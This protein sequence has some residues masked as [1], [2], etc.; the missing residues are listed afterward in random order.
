LFATALA[1]AFP[2]HAQQT[3][4]ATPV[5]K[6]EVKGT[7]ESYNV[8]RDD[9]ATRIVMNHDEIVKF[10]DT[11][12]LDVLKRLPGVTVSGSGGRGGEVRMRGLGSG[13]TQLLIDGTRAPPGL[14]LDAIAPDTI[15]RIEVIRA[16][17]ADLST[18]AI[19]G[20]IN[21]VLRKAI[22]T[23]QRELSL[24]AGGGEGGGMSPSFNGQLSDRR[25]QLSYSLSVNGSRNNFARPAPIT[26]LAADPDGVPTLLRQHVFQDD[27]HFS[28][29]ALAPRL[30]WTFAS[31][32]TLTWQSRLNLHSFITNSYDTT[33][34]LLGAAPAY[35]FVEEHD[36]IRG[37]SAQTDLNWVTKLASGA[38]LDTR[39]GI[40]GSRQRE[41]SRHRGFV[42]EGTTP[43]S[44]TLILVT[45]A[46]SGYTSTGKYA[47]AIG[48][49]HALAAGWDGAISH[50]HDVRR[51]EPLAVDD[52][53]ANVSRLALYAQDEWTVSPQWSVYFGARWEA[54]L[55]SVSGN[56]FDDSRSRSSVWS[57]VFQTLY[58]I[59]ASK[60]D[61]LRFALARTYKA[62]G[63]QS[64]IPRL[65]KAVNNSSTELDYR[66]NPHLKPELAIGFDTAYEHYWAEGAMV[67]VSASMREID[68]YTRMDTFQENGRWTMSQINDGKAHTRGLELE[69]KFPLK[70]VLAN[71]PAID[72]R[73]SLSRNWSSVDAVPGPGNRLAQ[74]TPFSAS[75]GVDYKRGQLTTGA[76]YAFR[77]GGLV[78]VSEHQGVTISVRRDLDAY[79]LWKFDARH[80]LRFSLSNILGQDQSNDRL[81]TDADGSARRI[82]IFP[83]AVNFRLALELKY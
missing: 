59:P 51:E 61:Q 9:T 13:Y 18:Q 50:R 56:S 74:Q 45:T 54:I 39:L 78:R 17:T 5:P 29:L 12:V 37:S 68:G 75:L 69:A 24:R 53:A 65:N 48:D 33:T 41:S 16:A 60:G 25:G 11:N 44:D 3:S 79:A 2:A 49:G 55:T 66:G 46:D 70:A 35:P 40:A 30:N 81:Y 31:G 27:G 42:A 23:A 36:R 77:N 76:S 21:I 4:V 58:K 73:A 14:S 64:L 52:Y 43:L 57:P 67:S 26:D 80:Q 32:D 83:A 6:V 38:K 28:R 72:L 71:A 19:A 7:T 15:E 10:G 47:L 8:R 1:N 22:K 63:T 82:A 34:T 62:P 20:T